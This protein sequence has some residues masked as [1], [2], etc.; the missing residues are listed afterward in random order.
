ME[1]ANHLVYFFFLPFRGQALKTPQPTPHLTS[2]GDG[3]HHIPTL[4]RIS[5]LRATCLAR[6]G[7]RCMV[8]GLFDGTTAFNRNLNVDDSG[9]PLNDDTVALTEV[10]HIIPHALGETTHENSPL[11]TQKTTFWDVMK[12]FHPYAERLL[13]GVEIDKP[14]NAMTLVVELHHSFGQLRW[15]LEEEPETHTYIFKKSPGRTAFIPSVFQPQNDRKRVQ[16]VGRNQTDLPSPD[17]LALHRACAIILGLSGAGEYIDKILRDEETIRLGGCEEL[18]L[19]KLDLV[20]MEGGST[21]TTTTSGGGLQ[22][23]GQN[24]S[25]KDSG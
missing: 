22:G 3:V 25:I 5:N 11:D 6:D 23:R 2:A 17:L 12:L 19:G 8:S 21:T 20:A 7:Y 1:L 24:N 13:D 10:A 14:F 9:M 18:E 16:F 4:D 15:Y